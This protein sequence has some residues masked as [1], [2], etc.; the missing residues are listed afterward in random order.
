MDW[1]KK[2]ESFNVKNPELFRIVICLVSWQLNYPFSL[3][4]KDS[5]IGN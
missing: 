4:F 3:F 2:L 5:I 1:E